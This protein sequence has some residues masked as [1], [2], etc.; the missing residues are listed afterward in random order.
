MQLFVH[1]S[2]EQ[3]DVGEP[4]QALACN[5]YALG[6]ALDGDDRARSL[7]E[8]GGRLPEGS[9]QLGDVTSGR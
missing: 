1:V 6:I 4:G 2:F 8:Q 9:A 5:T 7:G 3:L